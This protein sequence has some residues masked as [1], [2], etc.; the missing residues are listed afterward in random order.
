MLTAEQKLAAVARATLS[1]K[2]ATVTHSRL[3]LGATCT[4]PVNRDN[5]DLALVVVH[6][7]AGMVVDDLVS[8]WIRGFLD[9]TC[10]LD[11]QHWTGQWRTKHGIPDRW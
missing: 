11:L 6:D 8:Q 9:P 10:D 7:D 1:V 2:L 3:L 4:D 5:N